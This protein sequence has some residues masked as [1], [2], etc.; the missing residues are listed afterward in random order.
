MNACKKMRRRDLEA[1]NE[2]DD[3]DVEGVLVSISRLSSVS[4]FSPLFFVV[5][6]LLSFIFA[7]LSLS[8]YWF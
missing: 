2:R 8:L 1:E 5:V 7:S 6:H 4:A 3:D